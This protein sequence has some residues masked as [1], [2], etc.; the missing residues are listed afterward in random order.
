MRTITHP[1]QLVT[2]SF[3]E[4]PDGN[5]DS[6]EDFE[7]ELDAVSDAETSDAEN[8]SDDDL[9]ILRTVLSVPQPDAP[10][11]KVRKVFDHSVILSL[12]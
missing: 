11:H 2:V 3:E 5:S 10:M 9:D 6:G 8:S 12:Y 1:H 4:M 7:A